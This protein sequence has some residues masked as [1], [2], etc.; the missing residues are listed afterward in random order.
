[1]L[2]GFLRPRLLRISMSTK[3]IFLERRLMNLRD[4]HSSLL[5]AVLVLF[6]CALMVPVSLQGGTLE[7]TVLGA[8]HTPKQFLRVELEG[9]ESKTVFTG[10][11]G[12]FSVT[13]QGGR[14]VVRVIEAPKRMQFSV[15]VPADGTTTHV[16]TLAW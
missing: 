14:Y 15:D 3:R 9:P 8:A 13:L 5:I 12:K 4:L 16:F 2:N 11:D 10:K 6:C 7:G 1:M